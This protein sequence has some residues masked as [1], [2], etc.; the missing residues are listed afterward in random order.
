MIGNV[1]N[2]KDTDFH[3]FPPSNP[4][5]SLQDIRNSS[6]DKAEQK[7][8]LQQ[9][10]IRS[11]STNDYQSVKGC[12]DCDL[13]L[14]I[15]AADDEG[16]P[17][18]IYC[19]CFGHKAILCLLLENGAN[20]NV[21]DAK[22]WNPLLWAATNH[23][24]E[25][26]E[27]LKTYGARVMKTNTGH[28]T[29]E[30]ERI[31][32]SL[33]DEHFEDIDQETVE[34]FQD[35]CKFDWDICK[36]SQMLV[37]EE[38]L[39]ERVLDIAISGVIPSRT[40]YMPIAA[41]VLFM[42]SRYTCHYHSLEMTNRFLGEAISKIEVWVH[43]STEL[44]TL[45]YWLANCYQLLVYLK[46]DTTLLVSTVECQFQLTE[47]INQVFESVQQLVL[48]RIVSLSSAIFTYGLKTTIKLERDYFGLGGRRTTLSQ[49]K[50]PLRFFD[51]FFEEI[52]DSNAT[53]AKIME[54]LSELLKHCRTCFMNSEITFQIFQAVFRGLQA[55]VIHRILKD[56]HLCCRSRA[57]QIQINLTAIQEWL[58]D[59]RAMNEHT[60][61]I[62]K[63]FTEFVPCVQLL[64]F[65]QVVSTMRSLQ[66]F[67]EVLHASPSLKIPQI[68]HIMCQYRFENAENSFPV[69][70]E[71]Y[72]Q[73]EMDKQPPFVVDEGNETF[74]LYI[75]LR[76]SKTGAWNSIPTIPQL[77]IDMMDS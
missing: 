38:S 20:P 42:A 50:S 77:V 11:C 7:H 41:N 39:M 8:H 67:R 25:C 36:P 15:D 19:A 2:L 65:L 58:Y 22:G 26:V 4:L 51:S 61:D 12:I 1:P 45:T 76:P 18:V 75:P 28:G 71:Q 16:T 23:H 70:I 64:Q 74:P 43:G 5:W 29:D 35:S 21:Q 3:V 40:K 32:R 10:L 53:P 30:I 37:F 72:I 14:D 68:H 52:S 9:L 60:M 56:R 66:E 54:I 27:I 55:F 33:N 24:V 63:L 17:G 73:Q 62:G 49:S 6:M 44:F 34:L 48:K 57:Q 13:K 31:V 69:E 47:L 46:R 59:S